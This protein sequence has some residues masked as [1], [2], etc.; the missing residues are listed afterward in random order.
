MLRVGS[1]KNSPLPF[2][3]CQCSRRKLRL[4]RNSRSESLSLCLCV[5][6]LYCVTVKAASFK[7]LKKQEAHSCMVNLRAAR[8]SP[9]NLPIDFRLIEGHQRDEDS[10]T[11]T[12]KP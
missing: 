10:D 3:A 5:V 11:K 1:N 2:L 4:V 6:K 8:R 12:A 9:M 7:A